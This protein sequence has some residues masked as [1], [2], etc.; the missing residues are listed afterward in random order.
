MLKLV[1]LFFFISMVNLTKFLSDPA[2]LRRGDA[3]IRSD[4]ILFQPV[5]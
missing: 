3:K 4:L 1:H 5:V 2:Q